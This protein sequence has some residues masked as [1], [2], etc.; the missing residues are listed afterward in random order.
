MFCPPYVLR[1]I[2]GLCYWLLLSR[3]G[4]KCVRQSSQGFVTEKE[5]EADFRWWNSA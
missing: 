2:N 5:A 1:W 3:D 4:T